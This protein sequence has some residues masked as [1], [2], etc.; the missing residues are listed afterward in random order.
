MM[1]ALALKSSSLSF[2]TIS[3]L[4]VFWQVLARLP[5]LRLLLREAVLP[6][7]TVDILGCKRS[8][9]RR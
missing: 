3:S 6:V 8:V 4:W 1:K 5:S 2:S 9:T 7:E